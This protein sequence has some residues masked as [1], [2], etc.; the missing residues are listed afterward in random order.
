M[1]PKSKTT[2]PTIQPEGLPPIPLEHE[3][4]PDT[5]AWES[6]EP[7]KQDV[8]ERV[9]S[10]TLDN[11]DNLLP[12]L[13]KEAP[14]P[15]RSL[16]WWLLPL[17]GTALGAMAAWFFLVAQPH[18]EPPKSLA[19]LQ[20]EGHAKLQWKKTSSAKAMQLHISVPSDK[21]ARLRIAK[22]W[23]LSAQGGTRLKLQSS[24]S[25][26]VR[27]LLEKGS[28]DVHVVP[29]T[30]KT[31]QIQCKK[32]LTVHVRG[33]KFS[34]WQGGNWS[35][36][37]VSKGKV[38]VRQGG[39]RLSFLSAGQG[40]RLSPTNQVQPYRVAKKPLSLAAQLRWFRRHSPAQL[41]RYA[42]D[43]QSQS[44]WSRKKRQT[45]LIV[46]A[47][48]LAGQKRYLQS[49]QLWLVMYQWNPKGF[50][51]QN[52][53]FHAAQ[54]CRRAKQPQAACHRLYRK[55]LN[56]FPQGPLHLRKTLQRWLKTNP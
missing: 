38:E 41:Y 8:L 40:L 43:I 1:F 15:R 36:I 56:Q 21:A 27:M 25:G 52:A 33:T 37:E 32:D 35:R 51:G 18:I 39:K 31:F 2:P 29:G 48:L 34:V 47:D 17:T 5:P 4:A 11:F 45:L 23:S 6:L 24:S 20:T 50:E 55:W 14:P 13:Q 30:M 16:M 7:S 3:R 53:L 49:K 28:V 19:S 9:K 22:R 26:N 42:R 54:D 12:P 10:Q 46:A 44:E